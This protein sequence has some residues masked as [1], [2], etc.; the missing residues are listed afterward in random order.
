MNYPQVLNALINELSK[1]PSIGEKTAVRLSY[2]LV[3]S[4]KSNA[5]EL[6][7]RVEEAF[8]KIRLC[9]ECF[10]LTEEDRCLI[11]SDLSRSRD[12]ICV[13]EKPSDLIAIENSGVFKGIYHVLHG[14]WSPFRG[15]SQEE[16]KI[17]E[18][19]ARVIKADSNEDPMFPKVREIIIATGVTVEGDA[20]ASFILNSL[21]K[22][23]VKISRIAQGLPKGGELEYADEITLSH[24]LKRRSIWS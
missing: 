24:A 15:I 9:N 5:L 23:D 1:L 13:V 20:T 7:K 11:C 18:L 22:Y 16:T 4:P 8:N 10:S 14:L 21:K 2:H 19:I 6:A 12:I 3:S 17:T